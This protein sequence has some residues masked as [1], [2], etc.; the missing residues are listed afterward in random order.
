MFR[1]FVIL[2]FFFISAPSIII[3]YK[4]TIRPPVSHHFPFLAYLHPVVPYNSHHSYFPS[5]TSLSLP[6]CRRHKFKATAPRRPNPPPPPLPLLV[7]RLPPLF[8]ASLPP[9]LPHEAPTAARR[10]G[11]DQIRSDLDDEGP[12]LARSGHRRSNPIAVA[13]VMRLW[14]TTLPRQFVFVGSR[15]ADDH[16]LQYGRHAQ[17]PELDRGRIQS[18]SRCHSLLDHSLSP[19]FFYPL[20]P[21]PFSSSTYALQ[22]LL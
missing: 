16:L 9:P 14:S 3:S 13:V 12:D 18:P 20:G 6:Y 11:G 17:L 2:S 5:P 4:T 22:K 21:H 15:N 7:G 1:T 19:P 10:V 8:P